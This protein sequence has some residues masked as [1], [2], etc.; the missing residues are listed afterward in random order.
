MTTPNP[1]DSGVAEGLEPCWCRTK[2]DGLSIQSHMDHGEF[3]CRERGRYVYCSNCWA[4]GPT[5]TNDTKAITGWNSFRRAS[6]AGPQGD[7]NLISRTDA[8]AAMC[9]MCANPDRYKPAQPI[10]GSQR[11]FHFQGSDNWN[12]GQCFAQPLDAIPV[13]AP[14][15]APVGQSSSYA[16]GWKA[17]I[18]AIKTFGMDAVEELED[19]AATPADNDEVDN[20]AR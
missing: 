3:G 7:A 16:A 18:A 12:A 15:A 9:Y 14:L 19:A 5:Y 13:A 2:A 6:V 17:A 8:K 11:L 20:G 4:C 1:T 10:E